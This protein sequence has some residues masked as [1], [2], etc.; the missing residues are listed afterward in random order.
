MH[1]SVHVCMRVNVCECMHA[2]VQVHAHMCVHACMCD[3]IHANNHLINTELNYINPKAIHVVC[4]RHEI[5]YLRY[6]S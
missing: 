6:F 2:R 4:F 1:T 3:F 5:Y